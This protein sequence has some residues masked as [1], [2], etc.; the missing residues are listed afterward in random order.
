MTEEYNR[1]NVET[2]EIK[3]DVP[4]PFEEPVQ[5]EVFKGGSLQEGEISEEA[6]GGKDSKK[7]KKVSVR[8]DIR[9]LAIILAVILLITFFIK[10][11]IVKQTSMVP[12]LQENN[13][14]LVN[15]QAYTFGNPKKGDIV[16]F[17]VKTADGEKLYIKRVVG[18]PKDTID[19]RNNEVYV[20]HKKQDQSF[21]KD[22]ITPGTVNNFK[23]PEG[24]VYVM[25]DNRVVSIDSRNTN[26]GTVPIKKIVGVAF[27]RLY[28]F[29]K[30][31]RLK[32]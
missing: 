8:E 6:T 15:R 18:L 10:P 4:E 20:N 29:N 3:S 11:I 1:E 32:R 19:I 26:V 22:G 5:K 16:I 7:I 31:G 27:F 14:L 12:T 25:G 17:P 2:T 24:E 30:I 23:V 9:S 13:Y 21:T 28:P